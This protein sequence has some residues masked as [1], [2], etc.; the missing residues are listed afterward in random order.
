MALF[1][2]NVTQIKRSKGQSAIAAAAYRS[3]EKLYSEYYGETSDYT[4]KGGVICSEILLPDHAPREYT[5]RQTLWNAVEKAEHGKNAQ[6][7]YSFDIALQN[8]F[9]LDENIALARQFLLEHFV[10]RGMVVD[11]AIHVPDTEPGG[12]SNP[13]FHVLTPIRPIEQN[14]KWGMKQRRVYEQDEEGNRLL[15]A[16][17]NYIFNAVPTTDWGS[18]ETLEYWREQW[19]AMCNAKFEEKNLPCRIDHRSYERQGVDVLPTIHEGPSV[20]QME[21]KGIRTDKGDFNRWIKATNSLIQSVRK[22]IAALLD[23]LKETKAELAKPQTLDLFSL[24][25]AYFN[26]RNAG[27]YSQR[28]RVNNLKE[29]SELC[30]YLL[31][32]GITD[33]TTLE[34]HVSDLRATTD[35]LK[36]K[37][38][39]Q[40]AQMKTL[41]NI[42]EYFDDY[43]RLKPVFDGLQKIKF[44]KAREKYKAD[45]AADLKRFYEARRIISQKFPDGKFD[46]KALE[47]EYA[48][49]E[50]QHDATY[51]EFKAIRAESQTLW[52]IKSHID[53][54]RKNIEPIQINAPTQK[55]EKEI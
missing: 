1:H 51:S 22:K 13:H 18:P 32:H 54:A 48:A 36:K 49:L 28:A 31:D 44:T 6:L 24:L 21:A 5:D 50:Q 38:D 52:K 3:G 30:Q 46:R 40:T 43:K 12:I 35:S 15:D 41:R 2:L 34:A 25:Q 53:T 33:I 26:Q 4:N 37:L 55:Q 7:A 17:G 42:P 29:Y 10:S 45:H 39:T 14:G 20:R 8:E 47:A 23:W 19:A 16:D 11:F 27:A 9:S